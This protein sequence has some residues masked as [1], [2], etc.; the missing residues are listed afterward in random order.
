MGYSSPNRVV[1][2]HFE[3]LRRAL[4]RAKF[5]DQ[6]DDI[7]MESALCIILSVT[8][9]ETFVSLYF[10]VLADSS[11]YNIFKAELLKDINSPYCSLEKFLKKWPDKLFG[12]PFDF[13]NGIGKKFIELKYLRN[14]LVHFISSH[15]TIKIHN[16][17]ISGVAN[18]DIIDSITVSDAQQAYDIAENFVEEMFNISGIDP[19]KN[20]Q[21]L[22]TWIG[23]IR[24]TTG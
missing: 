11:K 10:R 20:N 17:T 7:I 5:A 15:D 24:L 14:K 8:A 1:W 22:H 19:T 4:Q 13:D 6:E 9:I 18:T 12:K 3:W 21:F 23:V 16:I 2:M